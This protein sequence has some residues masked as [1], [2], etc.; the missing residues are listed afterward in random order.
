MSE[1]SQ[2]IIRETA[3]SPIPPAAID[4]SGRGPLLVLF[5]SAAIWLVISSFFGLISSIKFHSP[6]FLADH[7]WLTYGRT[8]AAY[9]NAILYGFCI[10]AGLGVALWILARL[11]RCALAEPGWATFGAA[12]W[13][14][15]VT[16][17][18]AG[19]LAGDSTG[20]DNFE[21]P[22]YAALLVFLGYLPLGVAG[23]L[24]FHHRRERAL[25]ASQWFLF[26]ALFWF[27]WVYTTANLLLLTI[28]VRGVAQAIVA[29]WCSDNLV[30]VWLTLVGLA[31]VF[32]FIPKLLNRELDNHYLALFTFWTLILFASWGGIPNTAPVPSWIPAVS[33]AMTVLLLIPL[34]AVGMNIYRTAGRIVVVVPSNILLSFVL[35]AVL[36]YLLVTVLNMISAMSDPGYA[37]VLTWFTPACWQIQTYGFFAMVMF[38]AVYYILPPVTGIEFPYP[39]AVRL[40]FWLAASGIILLALPLALGGIVQALR[41]HNPNVPYLDVIKSTLPFLRVSTIGDLLLLAGHLLFLLNIGGMV[42]RFVRVPV[43]KRYAMVTADLFKPVES[44]P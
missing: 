28:P 30:G 12:L 40:H 38:G 24:T 34:I 18:V 37:L 2:P 39:R 13:N 10:Q 6:A 42:V 43:T 8:H 11:G 25:F 14:L 17:G 26:T 15:G 36:G 7:S 44:R 29:W 23:V 1:S 22:R 33:T 16:L 31:S 41:M 5:V 3:E 21:M 35:V 4:A 9:T 20:F 27:P 19:I 32:Y